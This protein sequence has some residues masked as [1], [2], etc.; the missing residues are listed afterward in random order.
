M[1]FLTA[2]KVAKL[3]RAGEEGRHFDGAGLYLIINGRHVGHWERRYELGGRSH[4]MGLGR[5]HAFTLAEARERN[6]RVSQQLADGIDPL[7]AKRAAKAALL[8]TAATRLTF[9]EA[10]EKFVAQRD[11]GWSS[12]QHAAEYIS[13]LRRFAFPHLGNLDVAE[14]GVPHVLAV[15]E[16]RVAAAKN[17]PTGTFWEARTVTA[18]RVRNR[19]EAVLD[20]CSARGHRPK[21]PNPAGWSGNLEHVLPAPAKVA[22]KVPHAAVPYGDIPA[23]M[24]KLTTREGVAV[25]ALQFLILVAARAGEVTG[26]VASEIDLVGATWTIPASRM[27][28]RRPHKVPLSPEAVAL[29]EGLPREAN[30]PHVFIGARPGTAIGPDSMTHTLRRLGYDATVHGMRSAFSTWAHE[31]T[32]HS[33]YTI[34]AALAHVTGDQTERAYKRTDLFAK[35][36]RLMADWARFCV[37][38]PAAGGVIP[39]RRSQ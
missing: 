29:L 14:I 9:R 37:S 2:K 31:T 39:L 36:R 11:A 13:S 12:A 21:G 38:P 6:R 3:L 25:K 30:N 24:A 20:F 1:N 22:R 27:K 15:L 16:Q 32:G 34:E 35:R 33:A 23:L 10:A 7:A 8:A 17:L 18:D 5:V 19:V 4:W 28:A 26:A